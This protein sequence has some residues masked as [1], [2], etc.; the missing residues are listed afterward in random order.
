MYK[1]IGVGLAR[2]DAERKGPKFNL[3]PWEGKD[4]KKKKKRVYVSGG[5]KRENSHSFVVVKSSVLRFCRTRSIRY[6]AY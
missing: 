6:T 5:T 3:H 2:K 4:K 1:S